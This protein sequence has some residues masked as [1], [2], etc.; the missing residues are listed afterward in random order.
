MKPQLLLMATLVV[1]A[2]AQR[3][4]IKSDGQEVL[5]SGDLTMN[6]RVSK[7]EYAHLRVWWQLDNNSF[8]EIE[9][10]FTAPQR[11][12][13]LDDNTTY[14]DLQF[15]LFESYREDWPIMLLRYE[16][17]GFNVSSADQQVQHTGLPD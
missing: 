11:T 10:N 6:V 7:D 9:D 2:T 14:S 13:R 16:D 8:T 12:L 5:R 17:T 1:S 3:M 4:Y 15:R